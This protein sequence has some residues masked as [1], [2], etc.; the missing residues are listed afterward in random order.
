MILS[1]QSEKK[2]IFRFVIF[3][4]RRRRLLTRVNRE[5]E[6][7]SVELVVE[8]LDS[9]LREVRVEAARGRRR[10]LHRRRRRRLHR[11]CRRRR[12]RRC[13]SAF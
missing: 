6:P 11:H 8:R 5:R 1:S 2:I 10:R 9:E 3:A 12:R 13:A 7:P 4:R